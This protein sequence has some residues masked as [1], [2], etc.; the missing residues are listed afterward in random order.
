MQTVFR[1][2]L[3]LINLVGQLR[4]TTVFHAT[5]FIAGVGVL[6]L[7]TLRKDE[8]GRVEDY[9]RRLWTRIYDLRAKA[10]SRHLALLRVIAGSIT[11]FADKIFGANLLS[12]QA[13]GVSVSLALSSLNLYFFVSSAKSQE[14]NWDALFDTTMFLSFALF[15]VLLM[16]MRTERRRRQPQYD[17]TWIYGWAI[18][19]F[20][21]LIREYVSPITCTTPRVSTL[22]ATRQSRPH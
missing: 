1:L 19:L 15:P 12:I 14:A 3:R 13:V 21:F 9:V 18:V 2:F 16:S 22:S 10:L 7:L 17:R 11:S 5:M 8:E 4:F 20:I 6:Y